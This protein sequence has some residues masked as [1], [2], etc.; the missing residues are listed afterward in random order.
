VIRRRQLGIAVMVVAGAVG[1]LLAAG[2][3]PAVDAGGGQPR[4]LVS[5]TVDHPAT[6]P[7]TVNAYAVWAGA[8]SRFDIAGRELS[9]A[10]GACRMR[11]GSFHACAQPAVSEMAY[12]SQN[13]AGVTTTFERRNGPCGRALHAF[14]AR[15]DAYM[16]AA[17]AFAR[18]PKGN[19][20]SALTRLQ[21]RLLAAQKSYSLA[22]LRVRGACRPG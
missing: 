8:R 11:L 21:R 6:H 18:L 22:G 16:N 3:A 14:G 13:L 12:E 2:R 17:E 7:L 19:P 10:L 15:L 1:V 20:M 9:K 4:P 5:F